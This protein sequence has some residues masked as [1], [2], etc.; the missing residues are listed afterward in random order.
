M[1][2]A[3]LVQFLRLAS[4]RTGPELIVVADRIEALKQELRNLRRLLVDAHEQSMA[5]RIREAK[6]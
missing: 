6:A 5:L 3:E 1:T 2:D 4:D